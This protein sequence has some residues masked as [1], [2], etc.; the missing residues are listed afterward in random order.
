[1]L[2]LLFFVPIVPVIIAVVVITMVVSLTGSG[3]VRPL[4]PEAR[5]ASLS[6]GLSLA[7]SVGF[8]FIAAAWLIT[9]DELGRGILLAGPVFVLVIQL[10]LAAATTIIS[11]A[12]RSSGDVR[13]AALGTRRAADSA[14]R[15]LT[16]ATGV[17][18][19]AA[20]AILFIAC[21][22]ADIDRGT[23][24]YRAFTHLRNDGSVST[25]AP[26]AG[27][28]YSGPLA[29]TLAISIV[30]TVVTLI[31]AQ[32]WGA[33]DHLEFDVT[34]RLGISVRTVAGTAMTA[35]LILVLVGASTSQAAFEMSDSPDDTVW[36]LLGRIGFPT[37][38]AFGLGLGAW[39]LLAFLAPALGRR[40][41]S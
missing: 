34:L 19:A 28:F 15:F 14:P 38:A 10:G 12:I 5:R 7:L 22:V 1:M 30:T 8:A 4:T 33:L 3:R 35:A 24:E 36:W 21:I 17:G 2:S 41:R 11:T 25:F 20:F 9:T 40:L 39:A 18:V 32:R 6:A 27:S 31:G 29:I 13:M 26:F 23:S 37:A 16:A